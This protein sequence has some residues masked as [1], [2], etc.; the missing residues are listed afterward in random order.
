MQLHIVV[1]VFDAPRKDDC[2][3]RRA[4]LTC[5][6]VTGGATLPADVLDQIELRMIQEPQIIHPQVGLINQEVWQI[7]FMQGAP[8]GSCWMTPDFRVIQSDFNTYVDVGAPV[9]D[10]LNNLQPTAASLAHAAFVA[11]GE[12]ELYILAVPYLQSTYCDTHLIYDLRAM[13]WCVW[14]PAGGSTSLMYNVTQAAVPQWLFINGASNAINIYNQ[15]AISDAGTPIPVT[16]TTT[17]MNMGEPT[18]RKML[19][20]IQVYGN[21]SM[22]MNVN[23][24]N[25]LADFAA[26]KPIVYNRNLK[27][28]PFGTWDLYLT[29]AKTK[30]RYYQYTFDLTLQPVPVTVTISSISN[31]L[32]FN[33][34]VIAV[35]SNA[36]SFAIG[37]TIVVAGV[38][39]F[40]GT[41]VISNISGN[42]LNWT[43]PSLSEFFSGFSGGTVTA[44]NMYTNS[45]IPLLGSYAIAFTPLDDL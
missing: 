17:W 10:I 21:T 33:T 40:N 9:Q 44:P 29:G 45:L 1:R 20:E 23:G 5:A 19:N 35:V 14:Q 41:F 37:E 26:P 30:H 13:K 15:L 36:S 2:G 34:Q 4:F 43:D 32:V 31:N 27:Q 16:A 28:S 42:T 39:P 18:R 12:F 8:A 38:S 22:T 6:G 7:V 3:Y 24:S 11:D 25:T